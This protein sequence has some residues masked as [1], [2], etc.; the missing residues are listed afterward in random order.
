M[1]NPGNPLSRDEMDQPVPLLPAMSQEKRNT[2]G[3][4]NVVR[5]THL[6]FPL[7]CM[8][9]VA[10]FRRRLFHGEKNRRE[11]RAII[12]TTTEV[13]GVKSRI[14]WGESRV[15]TIPSANITMKSSSN[16]R[17]FLLR[18]TELNADSAMAESDGANTPTWATHH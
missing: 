16:R 11:T 18:P 4:P 7:R 12:R 13:N 2:I 14:E 9:P 6:A 10:G 17:E 1:R 15:I 8:S 3:M 5:M